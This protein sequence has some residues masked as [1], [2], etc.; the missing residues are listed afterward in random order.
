MILACGSLSTAFVGVSFKLEPVALET[1]LV[2][3]LLFGELFVAL[4]GGDLALP[5]GLLTL[6]NCPRPYVTSN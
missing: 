3:A 2:E 1:E 5:A 4:P 6:A